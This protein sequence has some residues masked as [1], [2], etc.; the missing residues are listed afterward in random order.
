[1][2]IRYQRG[3]VYLDRCGSIYLRMS[4]ALGAAFE[5]PALPNIE[6]TEFVSSSERLSVRFGPRT[7]VVAQQWVSSPARVEQIAAKV[8]DILVN[9]LD[10]QEHVTRCGARFVAQWGVAGRAEAI[11][12]LRASGAVTAPAAWQSLFGV[13]SLG[14]FTAVRDA[15]DG[16]GTRAELSYVEHRITR[17]LPASLADLVS[18]AA[19]QLDYDHVLRGSPEVFGL[20]DPLRAPVSLGVGQLKDFIRDSW[21]TTKTAVH[22]FEDLCGASDDVSAN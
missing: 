22:K 10:I 15:V 11:D 8:W 14:S 17:E 5:G 21:T 3:M 4:D 7:M 2:E 16:A 1:M 6:A 18:P 13:P 12:A 20:A 19:V 9:S